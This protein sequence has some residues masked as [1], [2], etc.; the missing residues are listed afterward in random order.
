MKNK[1]K[2]STILVTGG[3]GFIGS[4]LTEELVKKG[5]RVVV[6][7]DFSN[8]KMENLDEVKDKIVIIKKDISLPLIKLK[9][10]LKDYKFDAIFHLA[11]HPR[12]LSLADPLRDLEVNAK[13]MLNVLEL[14]KLNKS[15]VIFTSNSGIYGESKY[16]PID[17]KHPDNPSTPYDANK[18]VA[19][20]YAKIYY[21]AYG[22]PIALCRL[23]T[24]FGERQR[25]TPNWKPVI[26]EFTEKI[27]NGQQPTIYWDGKQT[28][29]F[30]YV[31]DVVQGL[32][33][34]FLT[35][36]KDEI[37]IL[38]TGVETSIN[39]VYEIICRLLGRWVKPK[40]T[41]KKYGD[42]RRMVYSF[43]K[44]K[45]W[46]GFEP[47]YNLEEGIKNYINW[48]QMQKS[49]IKKNDYKTRV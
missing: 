48:L 15:K 5:A 47:R 8:G 13:G 4:H 35:D 43:K 20:Y 22:I 33:K 38:S 32:I 2:N 34:A 25:A 41:R 23:A 30:I 17:E 37:F 3:A 46:F 24:V 45:E 39:E 6:L 19:E 12:S 1:I 36:T 10:V 9:A 27:L 21:K 28:R 42:I 29:D 49:M 26:S 14:A 40:R 44:A 18:L 16:L 31:K 11:C 7:D